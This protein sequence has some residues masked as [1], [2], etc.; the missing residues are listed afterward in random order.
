MVDAS[1]IDFRR[2][3]LRVGSVIDDYRNSISDRRMRNQSGFADARPVRV[4]GSLTERSAIDDIAA[5]ITRDNPA[6]RYARPSNRHRGES[7]PCKR[8]TV[9]AVRRIVSL[10]SAFGSRYDPQQIRPL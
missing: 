2:K 8:V 5:A 7:S 10:W 9:E 1:A 4:A 6:I 3:N